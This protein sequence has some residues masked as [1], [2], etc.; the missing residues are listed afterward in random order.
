MSDRGLPPIWPTYSPDQEQVNIL[1][2]SHPSA[3]D[4]IGIMLSRWGRQ[5]NQIKHQVERWGINQLDG[6]GVAPYPP[7]AIIPNPERSRLERALRI[8]RADEADALRKLSR[9]PRQHPDRQTLKARISE[10]RAREK[11]LLAQRPTIPKKAPVSETSL[12]KT[13]VAHHVPYKLLIDTAR[14]L[15]ANIESDLAVKLGLH[16][17]RPAEAKKTLGN[18]L[19]APGRVRVTARSI[20]VDLMPS[21]TASELRAFD[22]FLSDLNRYHLTLPGDQ[23]GRR[24]VFQT[25]SK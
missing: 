8:T 15:L 7:D 5:E 21:G 10:A 9:L 14:V 19:K 4:I 20:R 12:S 17:T 25:L 13:L 24:L 11:E 22:A 3:E 18:L 16:L 1:C 23:S 6:R 2:I